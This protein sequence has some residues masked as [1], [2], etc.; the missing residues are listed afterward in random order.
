MAEDVSG[1]V[2]SETSHEPSDVS[3]R[4]VLALLAVVGATI[5]VSVSVLSLAYHGQV[6]P[7]SASPTM[8]PPQ[9]RLQVDERADLQHFRAEV[10][11]RLGSYGWVD[12]QHGIVHIPIAEAMQR[13]ASQGYPDWPGNR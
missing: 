3:A 6:N 8:L 10:E 4:L 11:K 7:P 5:G 13:A 1:R 2:R 9:P 12:R